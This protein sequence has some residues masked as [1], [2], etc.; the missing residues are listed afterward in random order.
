MINLSVF[1]HMSLAIHA[2]VKEVEFEGVVTFVYVRPNMIAKGLLWES[3]RSMSL[4]I[5]VLWVLQGGLNDVVTM[6]EH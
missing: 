3:Y 1:N 5:D 2:R 4:A 6:D